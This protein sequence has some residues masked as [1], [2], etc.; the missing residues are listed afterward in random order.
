MAGIWCFNGTK[1]AVL[2]PG[3][4]GIVYHL[5]NFTK[6][7]LSIRISVQWPFYIYTIINYRM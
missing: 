6:Y 5:L 3:L 2:S 4:P 1:V 7:F